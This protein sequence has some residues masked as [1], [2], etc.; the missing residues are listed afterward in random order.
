MIDEERKEVKEV[1]EVQGIKR[2]AFEVQDL[3]LLKH[4]G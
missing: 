2:A 4:Q 1:K 3:A